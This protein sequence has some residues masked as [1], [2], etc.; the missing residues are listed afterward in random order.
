MRKSSFVGQ[1]AN[2]IY[3]LMLKQAKEKIENF[4]EGD[5]KSFMGKVEKYDNYNE[6]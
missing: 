5:D 6:S 1:N 4:A 3:D 2:V